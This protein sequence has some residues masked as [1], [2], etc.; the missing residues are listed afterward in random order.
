MYRLWTNL[1]SFTRQHSIL[2]YK[3]FG[4]EIHPQDF[5][6]DQDSY[7]SDLGLTRSQIQDDLAVLQR[8]RKLV[9]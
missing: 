5:Y 6:R 2:L 7:E 4:L 9:P 1:L 3:R 8:Y